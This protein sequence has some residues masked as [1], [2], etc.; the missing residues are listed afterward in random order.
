MALGVYSTDGQTEPV[1]SPQPKS[2]GLKYALVA[3]MVVALAAVVFVFYAS[4][5]SDIEAIQAGKIE[6]FGGR[7]ESVDHTDGSFVLDVDP[8]GGHKRY[9]IYV[10]GRTEFNLFYPAKLIL[11]AEEQES[12]NF[13]EVDESMYSEPRT[14]PTT[15]DALVA[16]GD[17]DVYF[18]EFLYV[19]AE[20]RLVATRVVVVK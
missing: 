6:M 12:I 5:E 10:D 18:K 13:T 3:A 20:D 15:F 8:L 4:R 17:V 7:I 19:D 16:G 11:S 9:T 14:E 1:R 2:S